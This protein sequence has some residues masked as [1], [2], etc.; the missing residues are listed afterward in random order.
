MPIN[1]LKETFY[2]FYLVF[3]LNC[4]FHLESQEVIHG[5]DDDV[6][7][8]GAANLCPQVVLKIYS[9]SRAHVDTEKHLTVFMHR[10]QTC[11]ALT[12]IVTLA[13]QLQETEEVT[14][15]LVVRHHLLIYQEKLNKE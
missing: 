13:E 10:F 1:A 14:G 11:T 4:K 12:V 7:S 5:T 15:E 3:R 9:K 2:I 6:D 8:S